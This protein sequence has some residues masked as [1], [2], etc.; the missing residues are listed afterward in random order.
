MKKILRFIFS[1]LFAG[2]MTLGVIY[3]QSMEIFKASV[4]GKI[5]L[6][7]LNKEIILFL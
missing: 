2:L 4:L 7:Y 3:I 5:E 6:I 1:A